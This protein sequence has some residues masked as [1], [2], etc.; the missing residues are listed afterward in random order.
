M[1]APARVALVGNPN[2]GKTTLFNALTG[3]S[4]R[5]GNYPGT[6]VEHREGKATVG[7]RE[8]VLLDLPG[9]YSLQ[10]AADD[11]AVTATRAAVSMQV[12]TP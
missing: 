3:L 9:T 1:S 8:V 5:T 7:Q 4:A 6:T 10:P 12:R 2:G 11:E